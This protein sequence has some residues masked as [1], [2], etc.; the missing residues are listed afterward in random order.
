MKA[1]RKPPQTPATPNP[2]VKRL[3]SYRQPLRPDQ[4]ASH[5]AKAGVALN[6]RV[7][8][9][10]RPDLSP[11]L[12]IEG[13]RRALLFLADLI[14]A[15]AADSL[16][17]GFQITFPAPNFFG[18]NGECGLYLHALPCPHTQAG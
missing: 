7:L 10:E 4:I 5:Y 14:L 18:E 3:R 8:Q 12:L 6:L 16:D 1:P 9:P 11:T 15:Q 2:L 17:C 13:D